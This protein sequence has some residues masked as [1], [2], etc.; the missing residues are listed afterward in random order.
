MAYVKRKRTRSLRRRRRKRRRMSYKKR[1]GARKA[2]YPLYRYR[3]PDKYTVKLAFDQEF[4]SQFQMATL[5][6]PQ[7]PVFQP[8]LWNTHNFQNYEL[9]FERARIHCIVFKYQVARAETMTVDM[10]GN[11]A[12]T[13]PG[14]NIPQLFSRL[15]YN[16]AGPSSF[17]DDAS[18]IENFE[19]YSNTKRQLCNRTFVCK[20]TPQVLTPFY[21]GLDSSG[22]VKLGYQSGRKKP[23]IELSNTEGVKAPLWPALHLGLTS[24]ATVSNAATFLLRPYG[25]MYVTFAGKRQ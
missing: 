23:W 24:Q 12:I 3:R 8:A 16:S 1:G 18:L 4:I 11:G 13:N 7:A 6:L 17:P 15:D 20:Y 21:A 22:L 5:G 2:Y 14:I 19:E 9:L 25:F 10:T